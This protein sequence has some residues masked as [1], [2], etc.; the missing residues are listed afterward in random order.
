VWNLAPDSRLRLETP[1]KLTAKLEAG[2]AAGI[3][4]IYL[5]EVQSA[6]SATEGVDTV[7]TVTTGDGLKEIQKAR[8]NVSFGPKTSTDVALRA[9]ARTLGVGDGNVAHAV[10]VLPSERDR[11]VL[12]GRRRHLRTDPARAHG[13]L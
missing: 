11:L 3:S 12:R 7:T 10:A 1:K 6:R 13:L 4:Q 5:G 2:Y 9:I 8:I